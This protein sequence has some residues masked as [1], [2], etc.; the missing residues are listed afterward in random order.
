MLLDVVAHALLGDVIADLVGHHQRD[1]GGSRIGDELV[2]PRLGVAPPELAD[3]RLVQPSAPVGTLG[4][5]VRESDQRGEC[6]H[7]VGERAR[8]TLDRVVVEGE[9]LEVAAPVAPH[10]VLL[11]ELGPR[12]KGRM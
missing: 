3:R 9:P 5:D 2:D 12:V 11:G 1:R 6:R 8:L 10:V 7:L 4:I